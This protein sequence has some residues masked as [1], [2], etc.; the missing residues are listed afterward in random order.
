MRRIKLS[1]KL[2]RD[3]Y[4]FIIMGLLYLAFEVI[5][6][7]IFGKF[8]GDTYFSLKGQSS[9]WMMIVGGLAGIIIG[10]LNSFN[11]I[12]YKKMIFQALLGCL[13][14]T[15][16]EFIS[17]YILNIKL[18]LNIWD[19]SNFKINLLGQI[20]IFH[21]IGW[22]LLTPFI[23]WLDD[24]MRYLF[25]QEGSDYPVYLNYLTLVLFS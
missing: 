12:M 25:Y 21:S 15:T 9:I 23:I 8:S 5:F 4:I 3:F 17:G 2:K 10:N 13:I 18:G 19:Y 1:L 22:F 14:I 20:E 11:C 7:A 6:T 24:L 16:L